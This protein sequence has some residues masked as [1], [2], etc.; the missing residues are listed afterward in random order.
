VL[1]TVPA[2][3]RWAHFDAPELHGRAK[4]PRVAARLSAALAAKVDRFVLLGPAGV[5]KSTFAVCAL[6]HEVRDRDLDGHFV[7]AYELAIARQLHQLGSE[8]PL[9][10]RA[11]EASVLVLDDLGAERVIPSSPVAEVLHRRH[12]AMR[13][14]IVTAGFSLEQLEQRYGAGIFRR[15]T[16]DAEVIEMRTPTKGTTS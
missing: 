8:A 16:E 1:A 7:D 15:L 11:L 3:L 2:R 14:T 5:G 12:A 9:V 13:T 4:D 10:E 6:M